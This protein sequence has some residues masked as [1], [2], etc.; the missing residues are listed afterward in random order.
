M[1]YTI[2][3]EAWKDLQGLDEFMAARNSNLQCT[4]I[5]WLDCGYT[6]EPDGDITHFESPILIWLN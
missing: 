1:P 6:F 3:W 4:N 5:L 2:T